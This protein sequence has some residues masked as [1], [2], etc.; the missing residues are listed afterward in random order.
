VAD[1]LQ[2]AVARTNGRRCQPAASAIP[3]GYLFGV[4]RQAIKGSSMP[5]RSGGACTGRYFTSSLDLLA[6]PSVV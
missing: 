3:A 5:G 4:T 1:T 6:R 2:Q